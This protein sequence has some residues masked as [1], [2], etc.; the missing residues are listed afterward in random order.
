MSSQN[1]KGLT[2]CCIPNDYFWSPLPL[3]N[4]RSSRAA[5]ENTGPM[6]PLNVLSKWPFEL[7][8][9]IFFQKLLA[10]VWSFNTTSVEETAALWSFVVSSSQW[11]G[12]PLAW[13]LKLKKRKYF[14]FILKWTNT[15]KPTNMFRVKTIVQHFISII[16][17]KF[18]LKIL[19]LKL[20][21]FQYDFS[22]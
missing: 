15:Y 3:A 18:I 14:R 7:K 4:R 13:K 19:K 5:R 11:S 1:S 16:L 10:I 17:W 12:T 8:M 2:S 6:C 21:C 22:D 9:S 20:N